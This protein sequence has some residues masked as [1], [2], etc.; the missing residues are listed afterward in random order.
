[1]H[2]GVKLAEAGGGEESVFAG[3]DVS[4][5]LEVKGVVGAASGCHV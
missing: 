3:V 2:G 5:G 1:M 4:T